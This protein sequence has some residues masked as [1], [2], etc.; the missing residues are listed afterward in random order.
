MA[1][2]LTLP[3]FDGFLAAAQR[4]LQRLPVQHGDIINC[5]QNLT[6][7]QA[8]VG[9]LLV[10]VG[11]VRVFR[12][13]RYNAIHREYGSKW[14]KGKGRI[15]PE[16]AQKIMHASALYDMPLLLNYALAFALFKTYGIPTIS[17]LLKATKQ[18]SSQETI[19][20]RYADTEILISTW[21][22]CPISGFLDPQVAEKNN[23]RPDAKAADDPRAMIALARVNYL[24]SQYKISNDDYLYTLALFILQPAIW[25]K[26][27]G[28]RPL[29][30]MEEDAFFI[31]WKE[32]GKRMGIHDIP[33]SVQ[34]L[35][36]WSDQYEKQYMVRDK[37]NRE[38]AEYTLE[39]LLVAAPEALGIKSFGRRVAVCLMDDITRE[40]MLY[41]KQP[42]YIYWLVNITMGSMAFVQCWL[43]LPAFSAHASV[44]LDPR[45]KNVKA[46]ECPRLYPSKWT[47]RPWY[48]PESSGLG[49]LKDRLLV[50]LG[51]YTE[52]PGPH[53]KSAGYRLEEMGPFK[54]EERAHEE[55]MKKAAEL[56]GCPIAGP[57][58][59]EGR[60]GC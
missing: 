47:A 33:E 11:I 59:L 60:K 56:Q 5:L 38:V 4:L 43:M 21:F 35:A 37:V 58:S 57:W 1:S 12:W 24:H 42:W 34:A 25:A 41:E 10:W 13:R 15:T 2:Q 54:F 8:A 17:K 3:S 22:G 48:R 36:A 51:W 31:Y 26:Q 9:G 7:V 28:W 49:Y 40:A 53:L 18:L 39:E 16:E 27:Y 50:S 52:M 19:S 45:P 23:G 55:I 29:S 44:K 30:P 20:R 14:N 6:P 46:G 32:I